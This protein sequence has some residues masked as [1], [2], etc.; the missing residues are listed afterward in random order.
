MILLRT[1]VPIWF[2][3][4]SKVL[5]RA[6]IPIL[7][8]T[9]AKVLLRNLDLSYSKRP[10]APSPESLTY[11]V[12]ID[13]Q[14]PAR[15]LRPISFIT[16]VDVLF[17]ALPLSP[18]PVKPIFPKRQGCSKHFPRPRWYSRCS[19]WT[20]CCSK[21]S[22]QPQCYSERF[23]RPRCYSE[24]VPE[25]HYYSERSSQCYSRSC[26]IV[27]VEPLSTMLL[28]NVT[29]VISKRLTPYALILLFG[30]SVEPRGLDS[31]RLQEV[32]RI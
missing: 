4:I 32:L 26:L 9:I 11:H 5:L 19:A 29:K 22:P 17:R 13:P 28:K 16:I 10:P 30:G 12:Q 1:R 3:T 23:T 6:P 18:M 24:R 27:M 25:P 7:L 31:V 8:R 2:K 20:P 14:S 15:N 21:C